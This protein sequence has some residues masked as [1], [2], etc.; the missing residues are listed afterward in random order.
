MSQIDDTNGPA[1]A[2]GDTMLAKGAG[3]VADLGPKFDVLG[4]IGRGGMGSVLRVR[5]RAMNRVRA[6]KLLHIEGAAQ[7]PELIERFRR[8]ATIA[9]DLYH[10]NIV[11]I[12][13]FDFAPDGQPYIT[14]EYLEGEDLHQMLKREGPQGLD[15]T[16]QLLTGVADALDCVHELG[17]IHRDLKPANFFV[18][19]DDTVKILDFGIS[20]MDWEGPSLTQT[21]DILGTPAYMSPEQLRGTKV[22]HLADVYSLGAVAYELL[23]GH[24]QFEATSPA[25]LV[26]HILEEAPRLGALKDAALPDHVVDALKRAMAKDPSQRFS[27]A[28]DLIQALAG[29]E[30]RPEV[31]R[32]SAAVISRMTAIET[33]RVTLPVIQR[34]RKPFV[35]LAVLALIAAAVA[36]WLFAL[37]GGED[38]NGAPAGAVHWPLMVAPAVVEL[39]SLDDPWIPHAVARLTE[40]HL[41]LD[42]RMRVVPGTEASARLG[43]SYRP[44]TGNPGPQTLSEI[45]RLTGAGS[46]LALELVRSG[47]GVALSATV[48]DVGSGDAVWTHRA[49]GAGFESAVEAATWA[50]GVELLQDVPLPG[51]NPVTIEH[52]GRKFE[53]C[54]LALMAEDAIL[55]LG[56]YERAKR[57]ASEMNPHTHGAFWGA[58]AQIPEQSLSGQH[59]AVIADAQISGEPPAELGKDRATLWRALKDERWAD[60]SR[61]IG[62]CEL[63]RS[64]DPLVRHIAVR[65]N[66][67]VGCDDPDQPYCT[68]VDNYLDRLTCLGDST[69]R[70][71]AAVALRYYEEF[72]E[73]DLASKLHVATFSM[74]PMEK[75]PELARTWLDRARLRHQGDDSAIANSMA[76]LELARRNPTEALVWARRSVNPLWREGA[77]YLL[78]GRLQDGIDRVTKAV[79]RI[80][81]TTSDP[82]A[83]MLNVMIRPALQPVLLTGDRELC[84]RWVAAFGEHQS[85]PS[86]L[87]RTVALASAVAAGDRSM[88]KRV[89]LAPEALG[90]EFLYHCKRWKELVKTAR[91]RGEQ[92]YAERASRFLVAEANLQLE[93]YEAAEQLFA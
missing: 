36:V 55:K 90:L 58:L 32:L 79:L 56:L 25:M 53:G 5:H 57:L 81:G 10:P 42:P 40:M 64:R 2:D 51:T 60:Q 63:T 7:D 35:V 27:T 84:A 34:S 61:E 12:H 45:K 93:R 1:S 74:L 26:A 21:G 71:D 66:E 41:S 86:A 18:T 85:L 19:K 91:L 16:I 3:P 87:E 89:D 15:R 92:G 43:E 75:D 47:H 68:T 14:M 11:Q 44:F 30:L 39:A 72:A 38:P 33:E 17:V 78:S 77:S 73:T 29:P 69:M 8:E 50:L 4:T 31:E 48:F 22:D 62:L 20:H 28:H 76:R 13:D 6:V 83:Y 59:R 88:C 65:I 80:V 23:T 49:E 52:C 46:V 9:S 54:A 24:R 82:P 70:D 37:G 67:D